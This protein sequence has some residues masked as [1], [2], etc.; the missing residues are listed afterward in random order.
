MSG[1]DLDANKKLGAETTRLAVRASGEFRAADAIR[2]A[3]IVLDPRARAGLPARRVPLAHQRPE[4][5]RRRLYRGREAGRP[6]ANDHHVVEVV[7]GRR[8]ETRARS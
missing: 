5:L 2:K 3:R 1:L 4:S 8:R 7:A 6:G